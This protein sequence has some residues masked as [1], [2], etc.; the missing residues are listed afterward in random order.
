MNV[1]TVLCV[2]ARDEM[3]HV[4]MYSRLAYVYMHLLC[5]LP[6]ICPFLMVL[7]LP[8]EYCKVFLVLS[9]VCS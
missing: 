3:L 1:H 2:V 7:V 8:C 6:L 5:D 9:S 4:C